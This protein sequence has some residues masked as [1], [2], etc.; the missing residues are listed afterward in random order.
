MHTG[1]EGKRLNIQ[2]LI[3]A[4]EMNKL[5]QMRLEIKLMQ[6]VP[7]KAYQSSPHTSFTKKDKHCENKCNFYSLMYIFYAINDRLKK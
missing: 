7:I 5:K 4:A 3:Q 6:L 2:S 1:G